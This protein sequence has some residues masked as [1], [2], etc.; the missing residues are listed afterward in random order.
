MLT[1]IFFILG[2]KNVEVLTERVGERERDW[3]T[4]REVFSQV[5]CPEKSHWDLLVR[6]S[7]L[8]ILVS[9]RGPMLL[10]VKEYFRISWVSSEAGLA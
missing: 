3:G 2:E 7:L 6:A 8:S 10:Q 4:P 5:L 1:V 9:I